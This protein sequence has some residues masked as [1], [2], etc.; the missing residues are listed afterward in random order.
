MIYRH[1]TPPNRAG[2]NSHRRFSFDRAMKFVYHH[3]IVELA[4]SGRSSALDR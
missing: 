2:A 3:C 4:A 1:H